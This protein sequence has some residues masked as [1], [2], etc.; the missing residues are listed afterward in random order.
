MM[1]PNDQSWPAGDGS[2]SLRRTHDDEIGPVA[3]RHPSFRHHLVAHRLVR[4]IS[5]IR[6]RPVVE[7]PVDLGRVRRTYPGNRQDHV[8]EVR[9]LQHEGWILLR[10]GVAFAGATSE[11]M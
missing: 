8:H 9:V 6:I 2:G 7:D 5:M 10:G 1:K 3:F 4:H 11:E